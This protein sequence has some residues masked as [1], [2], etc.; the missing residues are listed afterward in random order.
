MIESGEAIDVEKRRSR[1]KSVRNIVEEKPRGDE[2]KGYAVYRDPGQLAS[3]LGVR[4]TY[5]IV[6]ATVETPWRT[7]L[8]DERTRKSQ[9]LHSCLRPIHSP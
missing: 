1:G 6:C 7:E 8:S 5:L 9:R 4:M 2:A 3:R